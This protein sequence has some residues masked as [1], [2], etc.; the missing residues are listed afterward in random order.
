[1]FKTFILPALVSIVTALLTIYF[2]SI[3]DSKA[4]EKKISVDHNLFEKKKIKESI[5]EHKTHLINS[6][7]ELN[8][9]LWNLS[10]SYEEQWH[11]MNGNYLQDNKY[12]FH[13]FIYRLSSAVWWANKVDQDMVYLDTTISDESD[14]TFLKFCKFINIFICQ[15]SLYK[16]LSYDESEPVDHFFRHILLMEANNLTDKD[17]KIINYA[18][19]ELI[20]QLI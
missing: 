14:L 4:Y 12:Y 9:R 8:H 15:T 16:G 7:E 1:M 13:S 20:C 5:A 2:K 11:F 17:G 10:H 3:R 19:F 6:F 18:S